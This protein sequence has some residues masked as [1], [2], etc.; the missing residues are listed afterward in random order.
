MLFVSTYN[1][2]SFKSMHGFTMQHFRQNLCKSCFQLFW[3][4]L[5][6]LHKI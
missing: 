1:Y 4:F 3:L 6:Q 2:C 5:L